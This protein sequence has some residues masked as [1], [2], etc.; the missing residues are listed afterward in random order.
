M[1]NPIDVK[2]VIERYKNSASSAINSKNFQEL[3]DATEYVINLFKNKENHVDIS[4]Q[5]ILSM[6]DHYYMSL[7][8]K[9]EKEEVLC[10]FCFIIGDFYL[11][12]LSRKNDALKYA[13][14]WCSFGWASVPRLQPS[15]ADKKEVYSSLAYLFSQAFAQNLSD[16]LR[17]LHSD[18][19][20]KPDEYTHKHYEILLTLLKNLGGSIRN[21]FVNN[22]TSNLDKCIQEFFGE[23]CREIIRKKSE[24][25]FIFNKK[26]FEEI[27]PVFDNLKTVNAID[28]LKKLALELKNEYINP[29]SHYSEE[30]KDAFDSYI[31]SAIHQEPEKEA[32]SL[33][34]R[35]R[36]ENWQR[37]RE[38]LDTWRES[39]VKKELSLDE[40]RTKLL[41]EFF[42]NIFRLVETLLGPPPTTFEIFC[43]GSMARGDL[44]PYSDIEWVIVVEK[45]EQPKVKL[46]F[47]IFQN[48]VN[49][50][51]TT[52]T[53]YRCRWKGA[54]NETTEIGHYYDATF[55][56]FSCL[57]P[58]NL[59]RKVSEI[60][61]Q[62]TCVEDENYI[63]ASGLLQ[64][65][66]IYKN[67]QVPQV[68][69][70]KNE[71]LLKQYRKELIKY[72]PNATII[73]YCLEFLKQR[74]NPWYKKKKNLLHFKT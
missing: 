3:L 64:V 42:P 48:L 4:D 57:D 38:Q 45:D 17:T 31:N 35:L 46:Y 22:S 55:Q 18:L 27:Q 67:S 7:V 47:E 9:I 10:K 28:I 2:D 41:E 44:G 24:K 12:N 49:H 36:S 29:R 39:L 8:Q 23:Y 60:F 58:E 30:A 70:Y 33:N 20:S 13:L 66:S 34:E 54:K 40:Y 43:L 53:I 37:F 14:I 59:A 6:F 69:S 21:L 63:Y 65:I 19:K 1:K 72:I 50:Y 5:A 52:L 73:K 71:S 74:L 25:S 15:Q 11:N 68:E 56:K 62:L 32:C 16:C 61:N 26:I 51:L